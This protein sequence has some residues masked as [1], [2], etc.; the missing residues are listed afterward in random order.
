LGSCVSIYED[1]IRG[2]FFEQARLVDQASIHGGLVILLVVLSYVETHA[3]FHKGEDSDHQSKPFFGD[4]FKEIFPLSG[5]DS[6]GKDEIVDKLY[7]E[8][9]CGLFHTGMARG[10]VRVSN[11]YEN[12]ANIVVDRQ[13]NCLSIEVNPELMLD[14]A[15]SHLAGYVTRLRDPNETERRENFMKAWKLRMR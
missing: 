1:Q 6:T 8:L 2:W 15:E 12:Y 4:G 5:A 9:R 14:Q 11:D 7:T 10:K 3:I 13:G